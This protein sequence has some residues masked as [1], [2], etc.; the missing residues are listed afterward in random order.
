MELKQPVYYL[1][2]DPKWKNKPYAT[3]G[4][5]STI[6]SAGCGPTS[7]AMLIATLVDKNVTPETTCAWSMKK[8][9]KA[10]NQGTYYT[11]FE[12]QFAEYGI[13]CTRLNISRI[14][15]KPNDPIHDKALELLD[16][17]HY[18]IALMGPGNWTGSGHY[19]V[20][21]KQNG[22]YYINDSYSKIARRTIG[23][24]KQFRTECRMY[25]A[26][27]ARPFNKKEEE[28]MSQEQFN[29]LMDNYLKDLTKKEPGSWSAE[30]RKW[31]EDNGIINGA[32][33]NGKMEYQYKKLVT[34]EEVITMLKGYD[35]LVQDEIIASLS[36]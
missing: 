25:W 28:E 11:Y 29:K 30:Q 2:V 19:V 17:G 1:Q 34:K 14:N 22:K 24:F 31:A 21:W 20:V 15:R 26:I 16:E 23:D 18:L 32:E 10:L 8:G 7:A 36:E 35:R 33:V 12:P 9:Y 3:K 13:K 4:E 5:K 27:D 6:G